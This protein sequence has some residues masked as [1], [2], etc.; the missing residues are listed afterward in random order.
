MAIEFDN[1]VTA[2]VTLIREAIQSQNF[3]AGSAGWQIEADGDAEFND[4]IIRGSTTTQGTLLFYTGTPA[5]GNLFGSLS[6]SAGVDEFGNAYLAGITVYDNSGSGLYTQLE[7]NGQ[8]ALGYTSQ[9]DNPGLVSAFFNGLM[10]A[11]PYTNASPN[12]DPVFLS[13]IPGDTSGAGRGYCQISTGT[14]FDSEFVTFGTTIINTQETASTG[15]IVDQVTGATGSAMSLRKNGVSQLTV[16]PNGDIV[17]YSNNSFDTFTPTVTGGGAATFS[18]SSGLWARIGKMIFININLIV[19]VAG[20]GGAAVSVAGPTTI[21]RSTRQLIPAHC[22]GVAGPGA[23]E[24]S[25]LCFTG[26]AGAVIDRL[27]R[28]GVDLVGANLSA[29]AN[30]VIEGWFREA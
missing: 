30:I 16:D 2:G 8:M 4:V 5:V 13:M 23:G 9:F 24:Y 15:L 18:T 20:S 28:G 11:S 29:G 6:S 1:P 3:V 10:I 14:G 21:A 19:N 12:D 26:G 22:G 7:P 17:T 25:A 27:S